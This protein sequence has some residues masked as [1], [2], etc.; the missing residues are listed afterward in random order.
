MTTR[1][2]VV[3][4]A[5]V[6]ALTLGACGDDEGDVDPITAAEQQVEEAET[7]LAEAEAAF[8]ADSAEYIEAV[9]RYGGLL[10]DEGATVGAVTAAGEDLDEPRDAVTTSAEDVRTAR[11]EL[12]TAREDLADARGDTTEETSASETDVTVPPA[13]IDRV[14]QAEADLE[15]AFDDVDE[16]T[17]LADASEQVNAAAFAVQVAW[18]RLYADAGCL[19]DD[20]RSEAVTAVAD[21]TVALQSSLTAAGYFDGAIDGVYGPAT[22]AAVEQLQDDNDLPATGLVDGA[23]AEALDAAV[24]AAGGAAAADELAHT[25]ALQ[26]LLT[27]TGHW[28]GP[29][30]GEWSDALT[31]AL[32]ELQTDLGVPPSGE[33]DAETLGAIQSALDE[34]GS[35]DETTTT[36]STPEETT[37]TQG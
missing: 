27:I 8:C 22:V 16:D 3:A 28:T 10:N 20:Q 31:A 24:E 29:I 1:R 32:T 11:D 17:M 37:S 9:D 26:T 25:A 13:S 23:T 14:E 15:N 4:T 33:L 7:A 34:A 6:L 36:T 30:D 18:L 21:Y 5:T 35:A 2:L 12:T 19:G